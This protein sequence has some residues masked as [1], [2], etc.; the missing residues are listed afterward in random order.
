MEI[1]IEDTIYDYWY[2]KIKKER[3]NELARFIFAIFDGYKIYYDNDKTHFDIVIPK[4]KS[5]EV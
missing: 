2:L 1:E 3:D 5:N 4:R